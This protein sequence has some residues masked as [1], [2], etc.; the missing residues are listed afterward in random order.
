MKN[1]IILAAAGFIFGGVLTAVIFKATNLNFNPAQTEPSIT[2][3][4]DSTS[5]TTSNISVSIDGQEI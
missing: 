1:L 5:V 3:N 2:E 4:Q